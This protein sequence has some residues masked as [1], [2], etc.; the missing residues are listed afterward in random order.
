MA[1]LRV[2]LY[3]QIVGHLV[4]TDW[5][6]F[7]FR[8]TREAVERFSLGSTILSE[9]I[10][11]E[12]VPTRA[13]AERR[14]AF[15]AE[16]L[17]EGRVLTRLAAVADA[18]EHDVVRLLAAYGRDVAGALQIYD[19]DRPGEPRTPRT[20]PLDDDG[21]ARL[22]RDV[23]AQPLGNAPVTGKSSLAGVQDKVVLARIDG[24]WH[25]VHD[26]H[27]STHLVKPVPDA[28]PTLVFDEE[29][30]TRLARRVGVRTSNAWLQDFNGTPGLVIERYD[31]TAAGER[32][33]QEDFNQVLGARGDQKYQAIGG[34]VSLRRVAAVFG[35]RG[36]QS[37]LG[38]LLDQ[39]T[40]AVG[41]GNL[42]L[43]TKNLSLLH[44][45]GAPPTLAPA[46]DVVPLRQHENDGQMALAVDGEYHHAALTV[47]HLVA[48]AE[49]WGVRDPRPRVLELL[50]LLQDALEDEEP[51]PR[52]HAG[53]RDLVDSFAR[54]LLSGAATG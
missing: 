32:I 13:R 33:H 20:T 9:A 17:P 36:D 46:Y 45:L 37:S 31:R 6:T 21:V 34:R 51:D 47:D 41:V 18:R 25:Q 5:R 52:A 49:S 16:L 23:Q 7:D 42:D 15:F 54:N 29:F 19:P 1:D 10:P 4:G 22:L 27:P 11:L 24:R 3:G 43:H 26:G 30:G 48:E 35:A 53:V 2:E 12:L 8:A 40:V 14:R 44:P 28:H 50:A 38:R 39:V